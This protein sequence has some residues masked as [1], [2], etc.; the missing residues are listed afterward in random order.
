MWISFKRTSVKP[1]DYI[2]GTGI[3]TEEYQEIINLDKVR[4]IKVKEDAVEF[5]FD[6]ESFI[7]IN[8]NEG[9]FQALKN[10]LSELRHKEEYRL[11]KI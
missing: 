10:F 3:E 1:R 6:D 8:K 2:F 4:D 9:S 5:C 11:I 7:I